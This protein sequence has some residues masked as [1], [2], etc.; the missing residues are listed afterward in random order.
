MPRSDIKRLSRLTA[1]LTRLQT[2]RL[3]TAA[4]LAERFSVSQRTIYRDV[5]ALEEAGVPVISEEGK[6]YR[7]MDHYRVPPVAFTQQEANALI[8]AKQL[9]LKTTDSSLITRYSE[10]IDKITAVLDRKAKEKLNLLTDRTQFRNIEQLQRTSSSLAD[11]QRAITDLHVVHIVYTNAEQR[12][13][14]RAIE[15]FALLSTANWLLLA[16]CRLRQE[17]RYFR[18]DRISRMEV[19][20]ERFKPHDMTLQQFFERY[21]GDDVTRIPKT[22][23]GPL[24]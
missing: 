16:R 5:R 4:E 7:L 19:L 21:H 18:L 23:A 24:T 3:V 1:I 6:G 10:A 12:T 20:A 14:Q 9:V 15:P 8:A 17:F 2:D 11:L 22:S 13:T